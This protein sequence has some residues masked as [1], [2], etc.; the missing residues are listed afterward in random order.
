MPNC[1]RSESNGQRSLSANV[2]LPINGNV[3]ISYK[4]FKFCSE[5]MKK[6]LDKPEA[7]VYIYIVA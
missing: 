6:M 7:M 1:D 5:L 4:K 3:P 2:K